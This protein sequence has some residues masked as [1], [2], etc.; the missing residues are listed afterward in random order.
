MT[1]A[2]LIEELKKVEPGLDVRS[3]GIVSKLRSVGIVRT[4]LYVPESVENGVRVRRHI[5]LL[6]G[7]SDEP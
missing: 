7:A 1:V 5:E 6:C 4:L 2:E 3:G